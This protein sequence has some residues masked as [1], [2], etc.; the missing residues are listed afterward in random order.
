MKPTEE[1]FA[2]L[3]KW[4]DTQ[5]EARND[6]EAQAQVD[7]FIEL[8]NAKILGPSCIDET[9]DLLEQAQAA[10]TKAQKKRLLKKAL[11]IDPTFT[12]AEL[13]LITTEAKNFQDAEP[14]LQALLEKEKQQLKKDGH[15]DKDCIG[16]FYGI[17]ETRPYIRVHHSLLTGYIEI[18]EYQKAQQIA[19]E[20]IRLNNNDNLGVRYLLL[21]LYAHSCDKKAMN[22]LLEKYPDDFGAFWWLPQL[23]MAYKEK[24][25]AAGQKLIHQ[26]RKENKYII[27]YLRGKEHISDIDR[28][29]TEYEGMYSHGS[30]NEAIFAIVDNTFAIPDPKKFSRW[31]DAMASTRT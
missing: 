18:G 22:H 15:F 3:Y 11:D 21:G 16:H 12:D 5:P 30:K 24:D 17:F 13:L 25:N 7:Q 4:L 20:I 31:V 8:Y 14:K 28:A 29:M 9:Y 1:I 6:Q 27:E 10:S 26:M 2:Q 19:K 23:I